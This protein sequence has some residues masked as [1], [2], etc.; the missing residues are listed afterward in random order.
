MLGRRVWQLV[1]VCRAFAGGEGPPRSYAAVY[2]LTQRIRR[3]RARREAGFR[4]HSVMPIVV[5]LRLWP[6]FRLQRQEIARARKHLRT[7]RSRRTHATPRAPSPKP[8]S[9]RDVPPLPQ[10]R[11]IGVPTDRRAGRGKGA[12]FWSIPASHGSDMCVTF[13]R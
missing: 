7:R 5:V 1:V 3:S 6:P 13:A 9:S 10:E 12:Q 4:P 2:T 8:P 11:A